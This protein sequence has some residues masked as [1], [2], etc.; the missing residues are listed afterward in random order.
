MRQW[1]LVVAFGFSVAGC[2]AKHEATSGKEWFEKAITASKGKDVE[3]T[4]KM[5]SKKSQDR[6]VEQAKSQQERAKTSA[7]AKESLR[8]STGV[9]GDPTTL[10]PAALAKAILKKRMETD[11]A[12]Y[13][14]VKFVE[15]K[16]EGDKVILITQ[17][18]G[19]EKEEIV[20]VKEDGFLKADFEATG[21]R[22]K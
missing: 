10:D 2:R 20:L 13:D 18:E 9:E 5:M 21:A 19:K 1:I 14:K 17:E 22:R 3:T 16:T 15:E 12:Q 7:E 6:F 8:K 4:W 11:A